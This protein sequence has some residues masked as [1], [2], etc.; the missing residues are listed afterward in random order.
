LWDPG[1]TVTTTRPLLATQE[2]VLEASSYAVSVPMDR[3]STVT[4]IEDQPR[5]AV[6]EK[7]SIAVPDDGVVL[8]AGV[9]LPVGAVTAPE[10]QATPAAASKQMHPTRM[11]RRV[12]VAIPS[13]AGPF[14]RLQNDCE[15]ARPL[16]VGNVLSLVE[17]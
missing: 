12:I 10:P 13:G 15:L 4:G 6:T 7:E 1:A 3:P 16:A 17:K 14:I 5:V 2:A 11:P 9:V 8:L